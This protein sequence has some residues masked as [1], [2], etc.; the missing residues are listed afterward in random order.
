[1][2]KA[3]SFY[4]DFLRVL[5]AFYVFV[6]HIG[7][8]QIG[9]SL[10]FATKKYSENLGLSYR[11]AHYFVIVFFVLSGYLITM[12]ASK[13][14]MSLKKFLVSRLGR[15]Y[16]VLLPAL[17]LS[18][19]TAQFL[20]ITAIF[21]E[22]QISNNSKIL[23]RAILNCSF[24]AE[25]WYLN[26]TP[27]LNTP[28]WSVHY[29][30]MYYLII[31]SVLLIKGKLKFV[32]LAIVLMIAGLKILL[33]FPCWFIGSVLYFLVRNNRLISSTSSIIL[34]GL[35]SILL[36]SVVSDRIYLPFEFFHGNA[37]LFSSNLFFSSN[38]LAD[39][40]FSFLV[41]L[42]VYSFFGFSKVVLPWFETKTFSK[43]DAVLK[44]IS[45]CSYSLYL[46]HMPL[47]FLF[48][49]F[50]FYDKTNGFHQVGLLVVILVAVYFIAKQ[51]EW[52]VDL[53]RKR[54]GI[55]VNAI[56]GIYNLMFYK[57]QCKNS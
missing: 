24:L 7:S 30:F 20:L 18:I 53:W 50:R 10:V 27:P 39:Y 12:A 8:M 29:E 5:A 44:T 43:A 32:F 54:T 47:L 17:L 34:F 35:T 9:D 16:S 41:A 14:M 4:L 36:V 55:I 37:M 49:S 48:S 23:Q 46:F 57:K 25:S 45:N 31:A 42:N 1:M 11:S 13:P 56:E 22:D 2:N 6:F 51:T 33:L 3:V 40:F 52:K 15:L 26:A 19:L 21:N 38:Y 28:F